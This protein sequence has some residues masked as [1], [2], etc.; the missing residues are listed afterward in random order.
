MSVGILIEL[1]IEGSPQAFVNSQTDADEERVL[2]DL[3]SR[4]CVGCDI[5]HALDRLAEALI[6]RAEGRRAA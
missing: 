3:L 4:R 5:V 6:D 1:P 2:L